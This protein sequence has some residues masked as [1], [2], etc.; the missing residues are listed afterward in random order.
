M[1]SI[2]I[3]PIGMV[4]STYTE[5]SKMVDH[6]HMAIIEIF[7][8]YVE[9]L[10]RIKEHS[11]LWILSWFHL[12]DRETLRTVPS[13][14]DPDA[15]EYGVFGMRCAKRPN[16]VALS[17]VWLERVSG[18]LLYVRELDALDGSPV[19]DIKP[20][21][22]NDVVFSPMA[23][24]IRPRTR[25]MCCDL[26]YRRAMKH[27]QEECPGL[28]LAIRMAMVAEKTFSR[29]NYPELKLAVEGSPC[30]GDT[31]QGLFNARIANP[32]RFTFKESKQ[33]TQVRVWDGYKE[34]LIRKKGEPTIK[35]MTDLSSDSF[36]E[37]SE[38]DL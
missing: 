11:H 26:F 9:A 24:Y 8:D 4:H 5:P 34:L 2:R 7:P 15:P 28:F 17:L 6:R 19:V 16:P 12:A 23:P 30:L 32:A 29:L 10:L 27:H 33:R 20:Y 18:N 38:K 13:R 22:E 21:F 36:L 37:V 1:K 31:L 14:V 25:E 3:N 35:E